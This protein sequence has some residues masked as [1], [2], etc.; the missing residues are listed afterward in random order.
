MSPKKPFQVAVVGG[1]I[2]GLTLAITLHHR[3]I[4]VTIYE[5]ASAF[6][7]V[8]AGVS[9]GPNAVAAM[10]TCHAGIHAA[11]EKVCTRN[12]WPSKQNVW[13]DYLDGYSEGS[14]TTA[15]N[16]SRQDIAFTISNSIG[17]TGV[18]RAH[19]LDEL[20]KLIPGDIARFNKRLEQIVERGGDGR[21]VMQFADGSEDETDLI[22]GCD[23]I[24]SR[25][26]QILVGEDHPA[27]NPSYTQKYA[28][29][30]LVPMDK[31]IEAIG[32]ELASNSCMHVSVPV[33][34]P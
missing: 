28:Y 7:E 12:L 2:A 21:L 16:A 30:G 15:H 34:P 20:I 24:K 9:F 4:P 1:G 5:Q 33:L 26:R 6:G 19:F 8:G 3:G 23:G 22:I 29:R 18:H 32:E 25:V 17:Q 27:A 13:F 14:S 11:F 31:A 10:K